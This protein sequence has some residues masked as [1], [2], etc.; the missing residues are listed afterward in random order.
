[1]LC[2]KI[3]YFGPDFSRSCRTGGS[4]KGGGKARIN[5]EDMGEEIWGRKNQYGSM[6]S[7]RRSG[8]VGFGRVLKRDF[9][10]EHGDVVED[11]THKYEP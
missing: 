7:Y 5:A 11:C 10:D 4:R 2:V 3:K 8:I 6:L 1:M 9:S